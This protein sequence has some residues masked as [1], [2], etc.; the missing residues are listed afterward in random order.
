VKQAV[1][2]PSGLRQIRNWR[3]WSGRPS[4]ET[5][6]PDATELTGT[7]VWSRLRRASLRRERW[8]WLECGHHNPGKTPQEV[9]PSQEEKEDVASAA[10][11]RKGTVIRS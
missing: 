3:V 7:F 5:E 1:G 4:S 9:I 6:Q 2:I 10:L 11:G 8:Q